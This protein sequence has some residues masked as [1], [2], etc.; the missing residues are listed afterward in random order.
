[1]LIPTYSFELC[2]RMKIDWKTLSIAIIISII[3]TGFS[4]LILSVSNIIFAYPDIYEYNQSLY[5]SKFAI[6]IAEVGYGPPF[7]LH[8][9]GIIGI[10]LICI[11]FLT[12]IFYFVIGYVRKYK[13]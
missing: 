8:L 2:D 7:V 12:I 5:D 11:L 6:T 3:I 1:M 4:G 9:W 10:G 13:K